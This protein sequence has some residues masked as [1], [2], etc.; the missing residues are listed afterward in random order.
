[1]NNVS[2]RFVA[3]I[4]ATGI[5]TAAWAIW[6]QMDDRPLVAP[7]MRLY[8]VDQEAIVSLTMAMPGGSAQFDRGDPEW[9][10]APGVPVNIERWGGV[11]LLLSGPQ[12]E[13]SLG[14]V[15]DLAEYGLDAPSFI[16]IGLADGRVV[17]VVVGGRTPDDL[18]HYV[19][20]GSAPEVKL[21][22]SDWVNVLA[23]L[24]L[25]PP[26][27]YWYYELPP[28]SVRVFEIDPGSDPVTLFLGTTDDAPGR[29]VVDG[30]ARDLTS[31]EIAVALDVVGGPNE[32]RLL[33]EDAGSQAVLDAPS[34]LI[35]L[36]YVLPGSISGQIDYSI[37]FALGAQVPDRS[38]YYAATANT[39]TLMAFDLEWVD[40]LLSLHGSLK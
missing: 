33:H 37:V 36:T 40:A 26:L 11:V 34:V 12:I 4:A 29:V 30:L 5:A 24:A 31:S 2:L 7:T 9:M 18:H 21:V 39:P 1:M 13:R 17:R 32:V 27:P 25:N 15:S 14:V 23:A 8:S 20:L 35:R 28:E 22:N 38:A 6:F 10:L 3:I 16:E 19:Q